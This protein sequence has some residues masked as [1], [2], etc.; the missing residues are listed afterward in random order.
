MP[1]VISNTSP[2][3]YLHQV[4]RKAGATSLRLTKSALLIGEGP[5]VAMLWPSEPAL[6]VGSQ[7]LPSKPLGVGVWVMRAADKN[8]APS[9]NRIETRSLFRSQIVSSSR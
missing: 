5:T 3:Q 9:L 1:E 7:P 4:G 2:I 6:D 8:D